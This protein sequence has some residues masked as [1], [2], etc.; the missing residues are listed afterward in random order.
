M[1]L[2]TFL[3]GSRVGRVGQGVGLCAQPS[4]RD[5]CEGF[6]LSLILLTP[7][8]FLIAG[9]GPAMSSRGWPFRPYEDVYIYPVGSDCL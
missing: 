6:P 1:I 9:N 5:Q 8:T 7:Y 4:G 3:A 2:L